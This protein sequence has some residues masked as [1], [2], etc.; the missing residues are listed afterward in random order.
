MGVELEERAEL[1]SALHQALERQEFELHYQPKVDLRSGQVHGVEALIRW[2]HPELGLIPPSCFIPLAEETGLILPI[3]EW[4]LRTACAQA[5]EWHAAGY[6]E[7]SMAVN[8]SA[9]Q[10]RQQN[11][12]KL[13]RA[14]LADTGL[15]AQYLELELTESLFMEDKEPV[16]QVLLQLRQIG[17][18]LSLDDFGTGYSSLSY[19]KD[20]PID[21]VK[22]DRSFVCNVTDSVEGASLTRSVIAMARSLKMLTVAEGVE[23]EGQLSF[24]YAQ[25]CDAI[26]GYY[27]SRPLPTNDLLSLLGAGKHLTVDGSRSGLDE[28]QTPDIGIAIAANPAKGPVRY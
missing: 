27:F 1:E 2:R 22:I 15:A 17:V 6:S 16:R 26:Q 20:F 24:L 4:V 3:G 13:V 18:R 11:V 7:L 9:R 19:L 5:Q 8:V 25:Q 23:T 21:I 28:P 12:L 10:F 14:V